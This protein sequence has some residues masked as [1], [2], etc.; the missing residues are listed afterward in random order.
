MF[1]IFAV[2]CLGRD[3]SE[4]HFL[5]TCDTVYI[6]GWK[7]NVSK[8]WEASVTG[9]HLG[10]KAPTELPISQTT[11]RRERKKGSLV[12]C[13]V[14]RTRGRKTLFVKVCSAVLYKTN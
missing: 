3:L 5:H 13:W 11:E 12:Y 6:L 1:L 4:M 8:D 9:S 2:L 7:V 14:R 10:S